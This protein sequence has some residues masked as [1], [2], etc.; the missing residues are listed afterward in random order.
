MPTTHAVEAEHV[1]FAYGGNLVLRD[2][3]FQVPPGQFVSII[4]P[5][6]C[7][8][9]TLLMLLAGMMKSG[10]GE[11]RVQGKP[12][13]GPGTERAMVFQNFALLPWK[14]LE[15]N[16][17]LGLRYRR[18]DLSSAER[19]EIAHR[20]IDLV[21]LQGFEQ[22]YPHQLSGGMQQ[23]VGLARA[24][25]VDAPI[26]LMDEPFGAIDAQNA[27]LLREELRGLVAQESRTIIFITHNLDEALFLSD[28]ILLMGANPGEVLEDV[29]L[30]LPHPRGAET[31]DEEQ[32]RRYAHYR[33]RLWEHLRAQVENQARPVQ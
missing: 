27:E 15:D 19:L 29:E 30:D 6:G 18:R 13:E 2:V 3:S 8:K 31:Q 1:S 25:A 4:G 23:R 21:G 10:R 20:A 14:S 22:H 11:L 26:L 17:A 24:F 16:V 12:V 9:S 7:G 28:R 32:Q 33:S 5:S